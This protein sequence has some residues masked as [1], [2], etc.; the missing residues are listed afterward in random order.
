MKSGLLFSM[1]SLMLDPTLQVSLSKSMIRA[2]N[3]PKSHSHE[4][5]LKTR[6]STNKKFKNPTR[7]AGEKDMLMVGP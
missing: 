2:Q 3:L 6:T 5:P 1:F 7:I 4:L